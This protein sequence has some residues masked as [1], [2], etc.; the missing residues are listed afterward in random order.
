M[1]SGGNNVNIISADNDAENAIL[2]I[3]AD[4]SISFQSSIGA[5]ASWPNDSKKTMT[6]DLTNDKVI[7][8]GGFTLNNGSQGAGKVLV[9]DDEGNTTWGYYGLKLD[10]VNVKNIS[11][12][13]SYNLLENTFTKVLTWETQENNT[14][15][16]ILPVIS[17]ESKGN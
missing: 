16:F 15:D 3:Q 8:D 4:E 5:G 17:S 6:I 10:Y 12:G 14:P 7:V 9:S 13:S 11:F 1:N 2:S